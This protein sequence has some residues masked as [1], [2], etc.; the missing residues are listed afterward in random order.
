MVIRHICAASA[1]P[2][3][4]DLLSVGEREKSD[5]AEVTACVVVRFQLPIVHVV[6]IL[7]VLW[8]ALFVVADMPLRPAAHAMIAP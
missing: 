7:I 8:P 2:P 3:E 1:L 4:L 5:R 6:E